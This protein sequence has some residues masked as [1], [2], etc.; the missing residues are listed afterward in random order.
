MSPDREFAS[1][2]EILR[3]KRTAALIAEAQLIHDVLPGP[4][5]DDAARRAIREAML[6][7]TLRRITATERDRIL[8]I[9]S[10]VTAYDPLPPTDR[11]ARPSFHD[12]ATHD[13]LA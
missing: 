5:R 13:P 7:F 9:L 12:P 10:F 1:L 8:D 3:D 11:P 2:P 4:E 6:L